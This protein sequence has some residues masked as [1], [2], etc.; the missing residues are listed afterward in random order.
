M[1]LAELQ[2]WLDAH[3]QH[4][5]IDGIGGPATRTAIAAAFTSTNA[6]AVNGLDIQDLATRLGCTVKQIKAVAR[7]ESGGSAFDDMGRPK[8]LF[9]RHYF[10]RLTNGRH[11]VTSFSNPKGGGY[12][13]SSWEKLT[14]AAC[15]D[16]Q[17][18][19]ASASWGKFQVM[20]AHWKALGYPS[21]LEMAYS[22]VGSEAAHYEMLARFIEHN[23]LKAA[24]QKLSANPADNVAFAS[25]YNGPSFRNFRYDEKLAVAMS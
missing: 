24:L 7:V 9:E 18:A 23:G 1:T 20:G 17:A 10:W 11:G 3:G 2:Q 13:E 21:A 25:R 19:F 15:L 22:T 16:P 8:I 4:I 6:P 12:N 5:A 14:R